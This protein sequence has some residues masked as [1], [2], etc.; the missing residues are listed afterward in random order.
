M[1]KKHE[2]CDF[3]T[4]NFEK[5]AEV[6]LLS[7]HHQDRKKLMHFDVLIIKFGQKMAAIWPFMCHETA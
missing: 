5:V 2:K 3:F 4:L 1:M 7:Y 6:T